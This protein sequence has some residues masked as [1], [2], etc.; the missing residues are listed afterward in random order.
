[1]DSQRYRI[2][3]IGD[4]SPKMLSEFCMELASCNCEIHSIS[5]LRLGHSFVVV[6][7][8]DSFIA[9]DQ[10]EECLLDVVENHKL[11]LAID[12]AT[13][14]T[15]KFVKSDAFI[16]V[17]G[18]NTSGIKEAIFSKLTEGGLDIHSLESEVYR[19]NGMNI[20][21]IN[22]KGHAS[23]KDFNVLS[24]VAANLQEENLEVAISREWKL[25]I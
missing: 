7:M 4:K 24:E 25:L 3:A 23:E 2:V 14:E 12:T 19:D 13:K 6:V 21:V 16:R 18:V 10:I 11:K 22:I 8:V 15:F 1:M 9:P 20:F 17:K 5:S